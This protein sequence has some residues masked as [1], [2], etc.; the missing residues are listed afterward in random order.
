[1]KGKSNPPGQDPLLIIWLT[2]F[3]SDTQK[4]GEQ[5]TSVYTFKYLTSDE[6]GRSFALVR[7]S[8]RTNSWTTLHFYYLRGREGEKEDL[9][10]FSDMLKDPPKLEDL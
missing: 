6:S 10:R 3:F 4:I 2:R 5:G 1:M 8:P 7:G 9:R